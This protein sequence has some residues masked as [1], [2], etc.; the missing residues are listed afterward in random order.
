MPGNV[1]LPSVL[2]Q[3]L[4][5]PRAGKSIR[6]LCKKAAC[7]I[8]SGPVVDYWTTACFPYA[9]HL[10]S[11]APLLYFTFLSAS[12]GSRRLRCFQTQFS[13]TKITMQTYCIVFAQLRFL[14]SIRAI[15]LLL[16]FRLHY[17]ENLC[18]KC[19]PASASIQFLQ[20]L[21]GDLCGYKYSSDYWSTFHIQ[22]LYLMP[23]FPMSREWF[24][25][26]FLPNLMPIFDRHPKAHDRFDEPD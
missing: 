1:S 12:L 13:E 24:L 26:S 2:W 21:P 14:I 16:E 23:T 8:S 22:V 7:M 11:K 4:L 25:Y 3:C 6:V 9:T 18:G 20:G 19:I 15:F 5:H 10:Q 17:I